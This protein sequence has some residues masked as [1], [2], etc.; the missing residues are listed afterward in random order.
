MIFSRKRLC[1]R[2]TLP[3][4]F[5]RAYAQEAKYDKEGRRIYYEQIT[6][7]KRIWRIPMDNLLNDLSGSEW[8]YWTST[9]FPTN[10]PPDSTHS[11]RKKHGAI[12]PPQLMAEIIRFFTKK[13][14][15]I[16]GSLCRHREYPAG[17]G[18]SP[19]ESHWHRVKP[20]MGPCLS[21]DPEELYHQKR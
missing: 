1:W 13:G 9:I 5:W 17:R 11:L 19:K 18:F 4:K 2:L 21:G 20:G 10:Y 8:L 12:K 6:A 7:E 16:S 14:E 15:S 3:G